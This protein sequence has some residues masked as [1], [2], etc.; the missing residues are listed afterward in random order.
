LDLLATDLI[1]TT[2]RRVQQSGA[3]S[4]D[5]IR[6]A[7]KRLAGFSEEFAARNAQL[8]RFLVAHVY[9]HAVITQDRKRSVRALEELF[10]YYLHAPGSMPASHEELVSAERRHV[11]VC[12]Y[13]AGMTDQFLLR[14][15]RDHFRN[16]AAA[17]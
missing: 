16:S 8:K 6:R 2:R 13:I 7:P 1:E 15:H 17:S 3:A 12:D 9:E 5:D 11:A 10:Y 14:R 4:V